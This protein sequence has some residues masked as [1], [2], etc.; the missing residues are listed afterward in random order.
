MDPIRV[1]QMVGV[2]NGLTPRDALCLLVG[3]TLAILD[4]HEL[5]R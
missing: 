1:A 5:A 4:D 2:L 3:C